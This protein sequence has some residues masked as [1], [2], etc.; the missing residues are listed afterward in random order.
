MQTAKHFIQC[1][2]SALWSSLML[3]P[4]AVIFFLQIKGVFALFGIFF[5]CNP[6]KTY[7]C[8]ADH[9]SLCH[10]KQEQ[11]WCQRPF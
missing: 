5:L 9:I 2:N 8:A 10:F 1:L 11:L 3:L 4:S 7:W 6:Q